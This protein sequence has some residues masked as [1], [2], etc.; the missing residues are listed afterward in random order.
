MARF[1]AG[2][3]ISGLHGNRNKIW[4]KKHPRYKD[5]YRGYYVGRHPHRHDCYLVDHMSGSGQIIIDGK[6]ARLV[7]QVWPWAA[8]QAEEKLRLLLKETKDTFILDM[9]RTTLD[10]MQRI[11]KN[12]KFVDRH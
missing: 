5:L 4:G 10:A 8:K 1:R 6:S 11:K 2:D 3:I 9:A 7:G 12:G